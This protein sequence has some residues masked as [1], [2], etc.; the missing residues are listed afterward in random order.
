MTTE[1]KKLPQRDEVPVKK[2]WDLTVIFK[3]DEEWEAAYKE[4]A[5]KEEKVQKYE[6][7]LGNGA[8]AFL[9]AIEAM[10][11]ASRTVS[12]VYVY[13]HLKSDQDTG[14][15]TYQAMSNRAISLITNA[16]AAS[17]WFEPQLLELSEEQLEGYFEE[18]KDLEVYRHHIE[19]ITANRAHV[20]SAEVEGL[21]AAAGEVLDA[22]SKT[23]SILN[24]ADIEFP[25]V[26]DENGEDVQL[27]HGLYG[28]LLESK[29]RDVRKGAF[30]GLYGVYGGLKNT[31]A[32]TFQ[33][34]V[35]KNNYIAKV[36]HYDSTRHRALS[37]NHIPE[38]VHDTLI[39][40]VNDNLHLLHRYMELRK[41]LLGVEELEMYDLYVSM[42]GEAGMKYDY[43]EATDVT[44]DALDILGPEYKG[45]LKKAFEDRWIDIEENQGKRSG[46]YSSGTYDTNPYIL[47]NWHDS[48][49]H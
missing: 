23:F 10:F 25:V 38:E 4:A 15:N 37:N 28:Q 39:E 41:K 22:S 40:V 31:F 5:E 44:Y 46:A 35:K 11:D 48:F 45:V 47:L 2:T 24:N 6:G 14:N 17:S 49:K 8:D 19:N 12:K 16:Q 30:E 42:I 36:H 7:T 32:S 13:A 3:S 18:N 1:S 33:A 43:D 29:D 21:L 9:E 20:L 26:K 34:N 27:S